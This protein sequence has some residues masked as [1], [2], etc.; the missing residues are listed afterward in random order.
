[1]RVRREVLGDAHV[2][3]AESNKTAFDTD[4]QRLITEMAW[5][6]VW[7]RPGLDRATRHLLTIAILAALGKERELAMHIRATQNTGVTP[8]QIKEALHQVALY[9]GIPAANSAFDVTKRTFAQMASDV[10]EETD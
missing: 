4:F 6:S 3:R 10:H 1:M 2:D 5:G 9:A 8:D 7:S